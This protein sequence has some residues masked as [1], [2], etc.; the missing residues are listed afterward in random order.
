MKRT[1]I[2]SFIL[3]IFLFYCSSYVSANFVCGEISGNNSQFSPWLNVVISYVG[4]AN[5][6]SSCK[7]SPSNHRFCCDPQE[8]RQVAWQIG[9]NI[10]AR[11]SNKN[12]PLFTQPVLLTISGEG[13]DLFPS[14]YL[15]KPLEIV[16]PNRSFFINGQTTRTE[17]LI[18]PL[19]QLVNYSIT[20]PNL[21]IYKNSCTQCTNVS[22]DINTTDYGKYGL[23]LTVSD[24]IETFSNKFVF[25]KLSS[26]TVNRKLS[27]NGCSNTRI[28]LNSDVNVSMTIRSSHPLEE[29]FYEYIPND[30]DILSADGVVSAHNTR[31]NKIKANISGNIQTLNYVIATPETFLSKRYLFFSS[32]RD[33]VISTSTITLY[34]LS[35]LS[36]ISINQGRGNSFKENSVSSFLIISPQNA[37]SLVPED[38]FVEK[39]AVFP[40]NEISGASLYFIPNKIKKGNILSDFS[41][42]TT[43]PRE[44]INNVLLMLRIPLVAV[45][46]TK[47]L[48]LEYLQNKKSSSI[49]IPL[50]FYKEDKDARYYR[51]YFNKT[52]NFIL[53]NND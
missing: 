10:T 21:S 47:H 9:K 20:F 22:L 13:Y 16:N 34:R 5:Y 35:F 8:I 15:K 29:E 24:T 53:T 12:P 37:L 23:E 41:I 43:I 2:V 42:S 46:D 11:V 7:I 48:K 27:C 26:L 17:L 28:P 51:V 30:F 44:S 4:Q 3:A 31:Y 45:K 25:Y 32:L 33:T 18:D 1:V 39:V 49:S 52:G 19:F 6:T 40:K 50:E 14:M 36:F 38:E